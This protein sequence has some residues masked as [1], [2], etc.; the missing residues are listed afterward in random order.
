M[1]FY[2]KLFFQSELKNEIRGERERGFIKKYFS[3]WTKKWNP[4]GSRGFEKLFFQV[5]GKEFVEES[6]GVGAKLIFES[7]AKNPLEAAYRNE[8]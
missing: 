1:D 3:K 6:E 4:P 7:E 2:R 5:S 8:K